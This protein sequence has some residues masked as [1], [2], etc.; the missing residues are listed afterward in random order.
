MLQLTE[1]LQRLLDLPVLDQT[2][3]SGRYYFAFR[4]ATDADPDIEYPNLFG[5]LKELGLRLEKHKGP[6][7]MLVVDHMEKIPREN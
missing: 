7:D 3:L 1:T 6:V 5:A 4:Y 2:G